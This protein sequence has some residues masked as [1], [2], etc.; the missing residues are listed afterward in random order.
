METQDVEAAFKLFNVAGTGT[1][2]KA[3]L[4]DILMY[5]GSER[6]NNESDDCGERRLL[7]PRASAQAAP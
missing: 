5:E 3:E 1:M 7:V 4:Y 6:S 2:S